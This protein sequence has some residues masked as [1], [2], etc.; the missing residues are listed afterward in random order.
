[1]NDWQPTEQGLHQLS[2]LLGEFQRPGADQSQVQCCDS[3]PLATGSWTLASR[4][5]SLLA[6]QYLIANLLRLTSLASLIPR[7]CESW[8]G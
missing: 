4:F 6:S 2:G 1:M 7:S 3:S 8:S 5:P